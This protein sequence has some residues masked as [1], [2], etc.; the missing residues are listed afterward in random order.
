VGTGGDAGSPCQLP[1]NPLIYPLS[2]STRAAGPLLWAVGAGP[3]PPHGS[4]LASLFPRHRGLLRALGWG[5]QRHSRS[6][7]WALRLLQRPL[8]GSSCR[9]APLSLSG[10]GDPGHPSQ[11]CV[12]S[13]LPSFPVLLLPKARSAERVFVSSQGTVGHGPFSRL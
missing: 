11:T 10:A 7:L 12:P 2:I 9:R 1:P 4:F 6:N 13:F 3:R 5:C 8:P